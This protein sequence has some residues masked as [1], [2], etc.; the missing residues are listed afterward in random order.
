MEESPFISRTITEGEG[1]RLL[2]TAGVHGDEFE[3]MAAVAALADRLSSEPLHG[4]VE[5]VPVVNAAAFARGDR[6]AEDGLDLARVCPGST[7][8][9]ITHRIA[10]ALS[11][12]IRSSDYYIDLHTGGR[13]LTLMPLVG[14]MLH[15]DM[16]VLGA[17]RRMA[18]A[19]NLPL[20]WGTTP[21]LEG[22]SISVARDAGVPAIYVEHGGGGR[23]DRRAVA[24]FIVGC[25]NVMAEIRML[26][27]PVQAAAR[28]AT[29]FEDSSPQSG[30]LQI[31]YPSPAEGIFGPSV[32]PGQR[33]PQGA[34]L[35]RIIHPTKNTSVEIAAAQGGI[36]VMLR[37]FPRVQIG[38]A[39]A[40]IVPAADGGTDV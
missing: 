40:T 1:P 27:R 31:N 37:A 2:I 29:I 14:Y 39:L 10:S 4:T 25:L 23:F 28:S 11:Q 34:V 22:R 16:R 6:V 33:V 36:V 24:D 15:T 5:L 30:H 32:S 38:D 19:F 9:S 8:G 21:E 13:A 17:Q 3:P 18:R 35:G 20:I 12:L 7:N 26:D